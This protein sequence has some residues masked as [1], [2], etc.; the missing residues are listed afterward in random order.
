[1]LTFATSRRTVK[2][3]LLDQAVIAGIG[4]IYADESLFAAHISPLRPCDSLTLPEV[5]LLAAA[6]LQVLTSAVALKGS[7]LRD[8]VDANG[9]AGAAGEHHAVY[10]RKGQ[11]C[12]T[13]GTPL[14]SELVAQRTT[15]CCP[16]CQR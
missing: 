9:N 4:N 7:T 16:T 3:A 11:D 2:A 12:L 6:L 1:M 14:A 13:C 15:V 5:T 8:Y 10:G